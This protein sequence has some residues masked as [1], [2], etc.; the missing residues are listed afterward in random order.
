MKQLYCDRR[1]GSWP[2]WSACRIDYR[3][4]A[5]RA[6]SSTCSTLAVLVYVLVLRPAHRGHAALVRGRAASRSSPPSSRSWWPRCFVAKIFAES[7]KESLGLAR[8]RSAR[9]SAI[10]PH[11]RCSSP[12]SPTSAP[13]S[14]LVPLFL[15]VAFLAG[16]RMQGD[17]SGSRSWLVVVGG[18]GWTFALKDYQKTRI[19]T[20][21]DPSL[22][23]KGAGY[24]KI[25]SRDRGG[26]GRP[27]RARATSRAARAS[28]ATCPRATPTSS[29]RCS[30]RRS[31]FV[32]VV[33]V[34]GLYLFVLW[35]ALETAQLARDRVG[36]FL[37]A[38]IAAAFAFQVVYNVAMVAGLVP[39]QGPAAAAS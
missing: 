11:G 2:C 30:P 27:R 37:A 34:L 20:F 31:G 38:G 7:K 29:S 28:S 24:Q 19:Y 36:A 10:G 32:G 5:D 12:P 22:D 18:L 4:L 8:H 33:V 16:L 13:P 6:P 23:P 9:A 17:R 21:L 1:S 3:R 39:G 35:R 26:L 25:Q 15:A 14:R